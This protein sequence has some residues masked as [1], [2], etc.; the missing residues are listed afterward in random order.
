M[1]TLTTYTEEQVKEI[2]AF[3]NAV[4]AANQLGAILEES[5]ATVLSVY[6]GEGEDRRLT[7]LDKGF[8]KLMNQIGFN[9][10]IN[11]INQGFLGEASDILEMETPQRVDFDHLMQ[12]DQEYML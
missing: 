5:R 10:Y 9:L 12:I 11:L 6:S 7:L 4:G 1:E 8:I 3:S 2:S